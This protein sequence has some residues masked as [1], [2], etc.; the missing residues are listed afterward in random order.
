MYITTPV[1]LRFNDIDML[2]HLYNGQYQHL[3]D[4]GKSDYFEKVMNIDHNWH[5]TSDGFITA[6][7]T[8][9]Y[10]IP[11][12]L[13]EQ[14]EIQTTV[15]SIGTKSFTF[16]QRMISLADGSV[17]SDSRTVIVCY[18]PLEKQTFPIP[19]QWRQAIESCCLF[20]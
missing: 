19:Q 9:T 11:V 13:H 6:T 14:I 8:N 18:N 1:Q 15:E 17:K 3:Y 5:V 7:T 20:R 12:E 2:G 10:Y 16:Y 4:L